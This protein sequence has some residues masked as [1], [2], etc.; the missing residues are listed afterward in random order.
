MVPL[1]DFPR[2]RSVTVY[3][4]KPL[5]VVRTRTGGGNRE[6]YEEANEALRQLQGFVKDEDD[7]FDCTYAYWHYKI[8]EEAHAA[9]KEYCAKKEGQQSVWLFQRTG[10][11]RR[12]MGNESFSLQFS[13]INPP[14]SPHAW[15]APSPLGQSRPR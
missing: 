3:P 2:Y 13:R 11:G 7:D 8:P 6:E 10:Q 4:D 15:P 12:R 1:H 9:W 5:V 14:P